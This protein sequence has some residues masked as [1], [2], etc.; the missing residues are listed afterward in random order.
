MAFQVYYQFQPEYDNRQFP[1]VDTTTFQQ[2]LQAYQ[3]LMEHG[4]IVI[5][6]LL[7]SQ[8][9]MF[10]LMDA[11]QKSD[12]EAVDQILRETGVPTMVETNYT[13][14]GVTFILRAE[15]CC[16]LTMYLRWGF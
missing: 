9:K 15:Q 14:T 13:P 8:D 6:S 7:S 5:N 3:T 11:A 4:R 12:D 10:Q 2:S 1:P 16:T